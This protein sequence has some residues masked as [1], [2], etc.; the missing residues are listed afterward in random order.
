MDLIEGVALELSDRVLMLFRTK[1]GTEEG[2]GPH[3]NH[4]TSF[5][6]PLAAAVVYLQPLKLSPAGYPPQVIPLK[7]SPSIYPPLI[8][9]R[10]SSQRRALNTQVIPLQHRCSS[11]RGGALSP[12]CVFAAASHDSGRTWGAATPLNVPN[13][14]TKF[15]AIVL[16]GAGSPDTILMVGCGVC[17]AVLVHSGAQWCQ[18]CDV[19]PTCRAAAPLH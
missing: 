14:N 4:S 7:L 8:Q 11:E 3:T 19:T 18:W 15:D 1:I 2:R 5:S 10:C 12:G 6:A 16:R 9:S 17:S 13:P